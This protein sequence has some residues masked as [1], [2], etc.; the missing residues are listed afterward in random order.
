MAPI[1]AAEGKQP[2][3]DAVTLDDQAIAVVLGSSPAQPELW[4][5][6]SGETR[7]ERSFTHGG[8]SGENANQPRR[9]RSARARQLFSDVWPSDD[10]RPKRRDCKAQRQ[11][12]SRS[13]FA[14]LV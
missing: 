7:S 12:Q 5:R 1:I 4:F 13:K 3:A 6:A 11:R 9:P 14:H 2:H 8:E 10:G